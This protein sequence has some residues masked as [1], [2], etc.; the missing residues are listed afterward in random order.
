[1]TPTLAAEAS[2]LADLKARG[3]L[4]VVEKL[5]AAG[6]LEKILARH[7]QGVPVKAKP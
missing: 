5:R 7:G 3:K 2:D 6:E 4:I 1:M